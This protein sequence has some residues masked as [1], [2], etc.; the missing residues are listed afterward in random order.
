MKSD[1]LC[2]CA[3]VRFSIAIHLYSPNQ[4][5]SGVPQEGNVL[6]SEAWSNDSEAVVCSRIPSARLCPIITYTNKI[7]L[8]WFQSLRFPYY[9]SMGPVLERETPLACKLI[10]KCK[11]CLACCM[12][13]HKFKRVL[14][15]SSISLT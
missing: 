4:Q 8:S 2:V 1:I 10:S 13:P 12:G 9:Y 14:C 15:V 11:P 3:R 5:L 7:T 6:L